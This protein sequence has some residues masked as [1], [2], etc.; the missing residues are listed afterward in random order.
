M[1]LASVI[2]WTG[3][4]PCDAEL[5]WLCLASDPL[6]LVIKVCLVDDNADHVSIFYL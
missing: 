1:V 2:V 6:L 4:Q 5:D 3:Y